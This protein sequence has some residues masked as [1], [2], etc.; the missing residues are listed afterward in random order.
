ML[1]FGLVAGLVYLVVLGFLVRVL[2]CR[3]RVRRLFFF[4]PETGAP[5]K[6]KVTE[7]MGLIWGVFLGGPGIAAYLRGAAPGAAKNNENEGF[8][9][10]KH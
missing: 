10:V 9:A 2:C 3:R 4:R 5:G 8:T 7:L 6:N 1:L